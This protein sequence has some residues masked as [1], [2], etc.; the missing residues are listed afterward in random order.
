MDV[1]L[2]SRWLDCDRL[3]PDLFIATL[4]RY[5]EEKRI[6]CAKANYRRR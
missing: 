5:F 1:C 2:L 4:Q 3:C 6:V